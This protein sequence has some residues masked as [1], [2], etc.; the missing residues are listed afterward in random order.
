MPATLHYAKV[1]FREEAVRD[2]RA[3]FGDAC[4]PANYDLSVMPPALTKVHHLPGKAVNTACAFKGLPED[5][6]PVAL[7]IGL[8]Q[9]LTMSAFARGQSA[10][11]H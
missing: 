5:A 8:Y 9:K 6:N 7:S 4:L 3:R 10:L 2:A 1:P 11:S